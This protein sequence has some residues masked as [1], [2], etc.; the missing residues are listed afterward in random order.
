MTL[1]ELKVVP[2][3][4]LYISYIDTTVIN[5][6]R[7]NGISRRASSYICRPLK[8]FVNQ[9]QNEKIGS[10]NFSSTRKFWKMLRRDESGQSWYGNFFHEISLFEW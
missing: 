9:P 5:L 3:S 2:G 8:I 1:V 10:K 4:V 6:L 7:Y